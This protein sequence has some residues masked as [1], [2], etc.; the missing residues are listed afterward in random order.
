MKVVKGQQ[1]LTS[2]TS[3][4]FS[5]RVPT[6]IVIAE[7][8]DGVTITSFGTKTKVLEVGSNVEVFFFHVITVVAE[9]GNNFG[10]DYLCSRS[11]SFGQFNNI[12]TRDLLINAYVMIVGTYL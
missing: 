2:T 11:F 4:F 10:N 7:D 6:T 3:T 12:K 5:F 1:Q 8:G 9:V